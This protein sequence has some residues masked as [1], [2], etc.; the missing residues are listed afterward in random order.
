MREAPLE[1]EVREDRRQPA[2]GSPAKIAGA[3]KAMRRFS[4][5]WMP[6]WGGK[7]VSPVS[8][9][10]SAGGTKPPSLGDCLRGDVHGQRQITLVCRPFGCNPKRCRA[11]HSKAG[12]ARVASARSAFGVRRFSPLLGQRKK[13][14]GS[15]VRNQWRR[16]VCCLE[17]RLQA[18]SSITPDFGFHGRW[19][20]R[21]YDYR[22]FT[23]FSSQ[24]S[25]FSFSSF[26]SSSPP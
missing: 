7:A 16:G 18:E 10:R 19:D 17:S 6:L 5:L 2:G 22:Q 8:P 15:P 24:P 20:G 12:C 4:P 9:K 13:S 1:P 25:S 11:P 14:A 26:S 23:A 21:D 3:I